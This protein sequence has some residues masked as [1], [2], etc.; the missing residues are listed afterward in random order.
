MPEVARPPEGVKPLTVLVVDDSG[1]H[2]QMILR[3]LERY[4]LF[5]VVGQAANG[6]EAIA[7]VIKKTPDLITLDLEMPEMDGFTFLRWL[8]L[9]RPTRTV[10]VTS[11][12]SNRSVFKAMELGAA[13]FMVKPVSRDSYLMLGIERE[14]IRKLTEVASVDLG[15]LA[16][17]FR[18]QPT[19]APAAA[20]RKAAPPPVREGVRGIMITSSTGGPPALQSIFLQLPSS[21][22]IPIFVAQHMPEG[23]T[24][25]FAK[26]LA[27]L[28]AL[29]VVEARGSMRAER[30]IF[31]APGGHHLTVSR[32][33][34]GIWAEV[35]PAKEGDLYVP[36]GDRLFL[37]G[38]EAFGAQGVGV[39]L[40]GMGDDG[41][42]GVEALR[43]AGGHVIAEDESTCA[44]YGMPKVVVE[45]KLAH[46]VLPIFQ[47]PPALMGYAGE[48]GA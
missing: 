39:V 16:L 9:S 17:F 14:F 25:M 26:R 6:K 20:G 8:M 7:Q 13:D 18:E 10:V 1:F 41:T 43:R 46:E 5:K 3:I 42:R 36:S 29:P 15:K 37:S 32:R 27:G 35:I 12:E 2:R 45:R 40:T 22:P 47:I 48:G 30:G 34:D 33:E 19:R 38:A 23:F 21:F 24:G 31:I 4:P 44:V 28:A 11:R